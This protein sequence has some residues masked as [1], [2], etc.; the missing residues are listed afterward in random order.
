[1]FYG[2]LYIVE[3]KLIKKY[4]VPPMKAI[5]IE[6]LSGLTIALFVMIPVFSS[7]KCPKSMK[8]VDCPFGYFERPS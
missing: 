7:I 8:K 4:Y 5:G 1:M 6:G 3:E 2:G